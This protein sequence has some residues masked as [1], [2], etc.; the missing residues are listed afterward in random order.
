MKPKIDVGFLRCKNGA[1][2]LTLDRMPA[3]EERSHSL[4]DS[5]FVSVSS[6]LDSTEGCI[7]RPWTLCSM[8]P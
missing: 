5:V 3:E 6:L 2:T 1:T 8:S 4:P 7:T